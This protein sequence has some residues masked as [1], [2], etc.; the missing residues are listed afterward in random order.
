MTS[1]FRPTGRVIALSVAL[2]SFVC[3]R[4]ELGLFMTKIRQ[5]MYSNTVRI[6]FYYRNIYSVMN[7]LTDTVQVLV[8]AASQ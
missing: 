6:F 8:H 2:E 7:V 1:A 5:H 3:I 4:L